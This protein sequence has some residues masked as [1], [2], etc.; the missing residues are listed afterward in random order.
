MGWN[1]HPLAPKKEAKG[2]SPFP[3]NFSGALAL[4]VF[5]GEVKK[6]DSLMVGWLR[7]EW[8]NPS[9]QWASMENEGFFSSWEILFKPQE[10]SVVILVV[11]EPIASL[12]KAFRTPLKPSKA[13]PSIEIRFFRQNSSIGLWTSPTL[14]YQS[15]NFYCLELGGGLF[16][17]NPEVAQ[18][19]CWNLGGK[20]GSHLNNDAHFLRVKWWLGP[21]YHHHQ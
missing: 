7:W 8:V 6:L 19:W 12:G 11:T 10:V 13:V 4:A 9:Q 18:I 20:M 16:V 21:R 2:S 14:R 3:T 1:W 5:W 15:G 17:K